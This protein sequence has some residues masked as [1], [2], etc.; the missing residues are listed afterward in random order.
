MRLHL[1]AAISLLSLNSQV[2]GKTPTFELRD[3]DRVVF[4]GDTLIERE[5]YSAYMELALTT[6]FADKN[7]TFRNIG[8]AADTP[9]GDSRFGLS[10]MQAGLEPADEGWKQLRNQ[11]NELKPT[12]F[13]IGYGM[14]DSF[15]GEA[16]MPAFTDNMNKILDAAQHAAG[17]EKLRVLIIGPLAHLRLPPPLP[18]PTPHNVTLA[19]YDAA[20]RKLAAKRSATF[21]SLFDG[22]ARRSDPEKLSDNGIHLNATGYRVAAE[23]LEEQLHWPAGAWRQSSATESLRQTIIKKNEQFFHRSRPA[24]MAYIFGFRR[25]EQGRNAGEIPQFDALIATQEKRIAQLRLLESVELPAESVRTKSAVAKFT[26]QSTPPFTVADGFE[27]TLWAENPL[28]FKPIQ[29]NFDARGRLWVASSEVYPQIEPGQTANDK[30]IILEDTKGA[31]KADKSTVFADGLLIPTGLEI[32]NGGAYVAQST[33]LLHLRDT[34][35]GD[36]ADLRRTVLSGFG[37]EDTHH[38]LHTLRWGPDGRLCMNQSIYTRTDTETPHG[39]VRLKSGGTLR[40][41]PRTEKTDILFRGWVNSW[42]HQIDRYGQSFLTDGAGGD[43]ISYGVPGAM[44]NAYARARRLLGSASPG[45][46]PKLC[47]LEIIHSQHFPDDWQGDAITCDF[48]AHRVVRFKIADDG[49][50]FVARPMPDLLRSTEVSFRPIDVKLGPDGALYIADWSNPIINHGEVDFRDPRRDR[51]HGRIWRITAKGRPLNPSPKL[52][53]KT[54]RALF[55]YLVSANGFERTQARRVLI[56]R[57]PEVLRELPERTSDEARLAAL[58]LAQAF[59]AVDQQYL[60][61]VRDSADPRVRAA[62]VRVIGDWAERLPDVR[63]L[64]IERI[65]DEHPRVRLEAVRALARVPSGRAAALE[66]ALKVLEKPTD[67]FLD[68]G[69][70][71][72]ANDL[73]DSWI[74]EV[75]SGNLHPSTRSVEF[76]LKAIEPAKATV[77]LAKLLADRPLTS[78]GQGPWIE[79]IGQSGGSAELQLLFDKVVTGGLDAP[80]AVRA[81]HALA[82]AAR[83][84]GA[85]PTGDLRPLGKLFDHADASVKTAAIRLGGRWKVREL[86]DRVRQL[87]AD[88]QGPIDVR[89]ASLDALLD[90]G[91]SETCKVLTAITD[92]P[93]ESAEFRKQAALALLAINPEGAM[94][95]IRALLAVTTTEPAATVLWRAVLSQTNARFPLAIALRDSPLPQPAATIGLRAARAVGVRQ[96]LLTVL[97]RQAGNSAP[98]AYTNSDIQRMAAAALKD[99]NAEKGE[100]IYRRAELNC[101]SCHAI[102][103]AGGKVGPDM[104]SLGAS[105]PM[106][107]LV[108]SLYL[109]NEKIKEGYHAVQIETTEGRILT[110][111]IVRETSEEVVLRP[112][113]SKDVSVPRNKIESRQNAQS[114]MPAGLIDGLFEQEQRDLFRFMGELGKAGQFDATKSQAAKMWRILPTD[115][116]TALA[117]DLSQRGDDKLPNWQSLTTTV[118]GALLASEVRALRLEG[119]IHLATRFEVTNSDKVMLKLDPLPMSA[120]LWLDGR[121]VSA[122]LELTTSLSRGKHTLVI[123]LN[124]KDLPHRWVLRSADVVFLAE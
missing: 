38:N 8:W 36:K 32:G 79:L 115:P 9:S 78:D 59:D 48:R 99:G 94:R 111:V 43:G 56:E 21:V 73:A 96:D 112:A 46:Y 120:K 62:G 106:D 22:F 86:G 105:A 91:G 34:S 97:D 123:R 26:P 83:L 85:K 35:G 3:G 60:R 40:F 98:R 72:T 23:L 76:V 50:G 63:G 49:A 18:D 121:E 124:S 84:H 93:N 95:P 107:Y 64:L 88:V 1:F 69:L 74:T 11:L 2:P 53:T 71:L 65:S 5:Q 103:G 13:I 27:V 14:A 90:Y 55:E 41:D 61:I 19:K 67:R 66:A 101:I 77:V 52:T 58:W 82:E 119:T 37:T 6:R 17:A 54:T 100:L 44:Y 102:G 16:G 80:A 7:V 29:M 57:G 4:I 81:L 113:D 108:E 28:L 87:A 109:P 42:G 68:Y 30:I 110:G 118:A 117:Q 24:N 92:D 31:G 89:T 47:S 75:A 12:V 122:G 104:T 33:E 70:W 10:L 25:G 114:L 39:V 20:L 116:P 15:A 51:E 45:S